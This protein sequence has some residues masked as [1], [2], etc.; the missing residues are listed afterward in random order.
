MA[1]YTGDENYL[2]RLTNRSVVVCDINNQ[3]TLSLSF[4]LLCN[5]ARLIDEIDEEVHNLA[6]GKFVNYNEFFGDR[7]YAAIS[8][9][10]P[11][12]NLRPY[13]DLIE[14]EC[15]EEKLNFTGITIKLCSWNNFTAAVRRIQKDL[16]RLFDALPRE[17]SQCQDLVP[18]CRQ[19]LGI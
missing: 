11:T 9:I 1:Y 16:N 15:A 5:F 7:Y 17:Y 14:V 2:L 13:Y 18:E 12:V 4:R 8:T 19:L 3:V 10:N 6:K